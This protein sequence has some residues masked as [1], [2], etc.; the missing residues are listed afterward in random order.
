[1]L[2]IISTIRAQHLQVSPP[3]PPSRICGH[4][5]VGLAKGHHAALDDTDQSIFRLNQRLA[6]KGNTDAAFELGLAYMQGVGVHQDLAAAEHWF[7][8]GA[9]TPETRGYVGGFYTDGECFPKNL[10]RAAFWL[11]SAGR[12]GDLFELANAYSE[13]GSEHVHEA[14]E[15]YTSLL[16][17]TGHPEVRRAQLA[18]GNFVLDG[19]YSSGETAES[20][21]Q[22]LSWARAI[23]QEMLG[24]QEYTIA[25]A[26]SAQVDGV[27]QD[28]EM[29]LRYCKRAAAYNIDLAQQFY[30][31][32]IL[33]GEIP[34]STPYEGYAWVRLASDKQYSNRPI[35]RQLEGDMTSEQQME[36]FS[37]FDGLVQTKVRTGAYYPS[38]DPLR[39]ITTAQ[40]AAMPNDDPDVQLR[41]AYALEKSSSPGAYEQALQLYRIARD[42]WR[43]DIKVVL[44]RNYLLGN[45]G[46]QKDARLAKYWLTQAIEASSHPAALYLAQWYEG[47]GGGIPDPVQAR[48]WR[49]IGTEPPATVPP[50]SNMDTEQE[51]VAQK[52]YTAWLE[53][54]PDWKGPAK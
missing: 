47:A 50:A 32:G 21:A 23:A 54:H 36:A 22:N 48:A 4:F 49:L 44:G 24:Q 34:R 53:A 40:L 28:L 19:K 37:V 12:P 9:I 45:N 14:G 10:I 11:R 13:A 35:V 3:E 26:Y 5:A 33:A 18:L 46:V 17:A 16:A 25:V 6:K 2:V 15:L 29:W 7:A 8:R 30:G 43:M 41:R 42:R 38:D 1:M 20:H 52:L 51:G 27:P 39:D 31:R